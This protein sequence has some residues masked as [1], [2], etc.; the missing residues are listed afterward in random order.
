[1]YMKRRIELGPSG[2]RTKANAMTFNDVSNYFSHYAPS[3]AGLEAERQQRNALK[4][5]R[6]SARSCYAS[7]EGL[8]RPTQNL[9]LVASSY[10]NCRYEYARIRR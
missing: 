5:C 2:R 8:S 10:T 4:P 9:G 7:C 6:S 1:M 3:K